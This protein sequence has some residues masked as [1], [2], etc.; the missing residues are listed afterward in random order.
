[1]T[2]LGNMVGDFDF[3]IYVPDYNRE[4]HPR[5][6]D[7]TLAQFAEQLREELNQYYDMRDNQNRYV[8]NN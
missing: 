5:E 6:S 3:S 1:M 2:G 7:M 8:N 4:A